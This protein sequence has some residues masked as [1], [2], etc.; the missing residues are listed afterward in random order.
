MIHNR[1]V[2][3]LVPIKDHSERVVGKNFRDF[4]G[5]PLYQHI[6]LTLD[7]IYA[8]DEI[9]I[10]TDSYRVMKEGASLSPKV[11]VIERPQEL[12]GDHVS[13]NR[14]FEYDLSQTDADL[15]VQTHATNPL[16]RSE[17]VAQAIRCFIDSESDYDSLF[18]VNQYHSRF[19]LE[20]GTPVN[21]DPENLIRTQDLPPVFE[22]NSCLYVFT[23]ESFTKKGRRIGLKPLMYPTPTTESIDIDDEF[24]F[25]LAEL[26]AL[27]AQRDQGSE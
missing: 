8:V 23:K 24:T 17:T 14:V 10:D 13:T 20:D 5:K 21:H 18:S 25:R 19:Y 7:R 9:V 4:S 1:K 11:R 16:L 27:Y 22:E 26:L 6:V 15:Y 3:A 12:R 2:T